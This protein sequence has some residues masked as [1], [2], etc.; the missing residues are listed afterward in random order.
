MNEKL[1]NPHTRLCRCIFATML[2]TI[3]VCSSVMCAYAS[4][5][6]D[7]GT[8]SAIIAGIENGTDQIMQI[9]TSITKPIAGVCL[10]IAFFLILFGG[11]RGLEKAKTK[12]LTILLAIAGVC[13]AIPMVDEV[14]KWFGA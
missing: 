9:I 10:A 14:A 1:T 11:E 3:I 4:G 7:P 12:A 8:G 13:Y 5:P 6:D 2:V